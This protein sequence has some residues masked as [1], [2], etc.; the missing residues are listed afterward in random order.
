MQEKWNK[1]VYY[2][3]DAKKNIVKESECYLMK[4]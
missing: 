2:L 1:F 3:H 4:D